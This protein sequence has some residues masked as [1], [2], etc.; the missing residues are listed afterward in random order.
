MGSLI[1]LSDNAPAAPYVLLLL[2]G[3]L[4]LLCYCC[5][6]S[7]HRHSGG[8]LLA[9]PR[10]CQTC[11]TS[12][13]CFHPVPPMALQPGDGNRNLS[14]LREAPSG[15]GALSFISTSLSASTLGSSYWSCPGTPR[16]GPTTIS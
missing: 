6:R 5:L 14:V 3:G 9:W 4:G 16:C 1:S 15:C 2:R 8:A 11:R 7:Q 10:P 13:N 12:R